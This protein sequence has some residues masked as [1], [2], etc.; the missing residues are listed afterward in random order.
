MEEHTLRKKS[1]TTSPPYPPTGRQPINFSTGDKNSEVCPYYSFF[2]EVTQ[3]L[4]QQ[5]FAI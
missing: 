1:G 3:I 2:L 4:N 5:V